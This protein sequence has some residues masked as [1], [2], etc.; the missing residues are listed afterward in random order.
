[1][2]K[3]QIFKNEYCVYEK[4]CFMLTNFLRQYMIY[5]NSFYFIGDE[6]TYVVT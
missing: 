3:L 1:L 4:I 5:V 6:K 2:D